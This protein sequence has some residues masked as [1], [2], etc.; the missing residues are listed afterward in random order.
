IDLKAAYGRRYRV[1]WD[2][3]ASIPDQ[4]AED[5]AWLQIVEAK[6]GHIFIHSERELGVYV[7]TKGDPTNR[8]GRLLAIPGSRLRQRGDHPATVVIPDEQFEQAAAIIHARKRRQLSA[9]H[10]AKLTA[11]AAP[12]RF[13]PGR[14]PH[15]D[16]GSGAQGTGLETTDALSD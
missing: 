6:Y 5:R 7:R 2:E 16:S 10:Q 3:S 12:F 13:Q 9:E 1:S 11:A 14:S 8:L 15:S 4:S